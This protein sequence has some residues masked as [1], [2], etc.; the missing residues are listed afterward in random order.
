MEE[1]QNLNIDEL[2]LQ[3]ALDNQILTSEDQIQEVP[4]DTP[5]QP[6][7]RQEP[8][9]EGQEEVQMPFGMKAPRPGVGGFLHDMGEGMWQKAA[10]IVGISDTII[11]TLNFLE[12]GRG[13][14]IPKLPAYED[15]TVQALRNISGL[16]IPT[17]G[18]RSMVLSGGAINPHGAITYKM[19]V[20]AGAQIGASYNPRNGSATAGDGATSGSSCVTEVED[21]WIVAF[22][23]I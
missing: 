4:T 20:I 18:L 23:G 14:E 7:V 10:P 2:D 21:G 8:S 5:Q 12:A 17:L 16:I 13:V 3:N 1:D 6:E 19:P 15:K 22:T 9:T 11:D